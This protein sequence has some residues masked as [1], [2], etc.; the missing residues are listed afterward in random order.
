MVDLGSFGGSNSTDDVS[1]RS[2]IP[3]KLKYINLKVFGIL[4]TIN[5]SQ[6]H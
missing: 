3:N 5:E 2:S 6:L 1:D 4:K